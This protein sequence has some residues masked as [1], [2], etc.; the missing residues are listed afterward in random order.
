MIGR[1]NTTAVNYPATLATEAVVR[2]TDL[3]FM[4]AFHIRHHI[5]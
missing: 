2:F 1:V 3:V 4:K 5:N